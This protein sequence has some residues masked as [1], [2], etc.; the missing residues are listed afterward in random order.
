MTEESKMSPEKRHDDEEE[1]DHDSEHCYIAPT[2]K[3]TVVNFVQD[4]DEW[5]DND[6]EGLR[7][8]LLR[9]KGYRK[10]VSIGMA[11]YSKFNKWN[12]VIGVLLV[13]LVTFISSYNAVSTASND[14]TLSAA[15]TY[16]IAIC[17]LFKMVSM[18]VEPVLNFKKRERLCEKLEESC[19]ILADAVEELLGTPHNRRQQAGKVLSNI[20]LRYLRVQKGVADAK[21]VSEFGPVYRDYIASLK[22]DETA[23]QKY[24]ETVNDILL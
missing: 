19:S 8:T 13:S 18:S 12:G 7:D 15:G 2:V 4:R 11:Y 10:L 1:V 6:D 17:S 3:R 20:Q 16:L 23:K 5:L 21:L 24:L 22:G 9:V 14:S